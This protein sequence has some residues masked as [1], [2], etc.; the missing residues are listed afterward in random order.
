MTAQEIDIHPLTLDRWPDLEA[1]FSRERAPNE[2]W[3]MYWRIPRREWQRQKGE[4]NRLALKRIVESG[5]VP[6]LLAYAGSRPAGWVSVGPREVF[7][8]AQ[9]LAALP[10][11]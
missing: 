2:C 5:E 6:G 4:G 11:D 1:L 10:E 3:C 9:S 7:S 8:V